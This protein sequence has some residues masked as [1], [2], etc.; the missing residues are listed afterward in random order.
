MIFIVMVVRWRW[1]NKTVACA[2][3]GM[4]VLL[5]EHYGSIPEMTVDKPTH[6]RKVCRWWRTVDAHEGVRE[7]FAMNGV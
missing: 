1:P 3:L 7:L 4:H 5:R 2:W 6:H